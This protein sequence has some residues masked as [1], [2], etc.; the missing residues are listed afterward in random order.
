M[1]IVYNIAVSIKIIS[2]EKEYYYAGRT[3]YFRNFK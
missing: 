3:D 2:L 1:L